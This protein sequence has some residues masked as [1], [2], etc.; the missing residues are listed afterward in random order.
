VVPASREGRR[1]RGDVDGLRA[2]AIL[3]VVAFHVGVPGFSG[4]FVGVDVFFVISGFLITGNLLTES[5][6][7][8]R[9]GLVRFWARRIRRLVPPLALMLVVVSVLTLAILPYVEWQTVAAQ[10]RAAALYVSNLV[11]ARQ[12]TDYFAP[13]VNTSLFLHTWSLGVEEQF[14]L[15]WPVLVVAAAL[16][17]RRRRRWLRPLLAVIFSATLV[18]SFA[19]CL[20]QTTAGSPYAFF[21]LPARAWEF[22]AAGLLALSPVPR[23]LARRVPQLAAFVVGAGL[24]VTATLVYDQQSPYPG[25]R[26]LLPVVG[27]VLMILAGT[28]RGAATT[29]PLSVALSARPMQW[30]GRVSYSW[31]LWHWPFILLAVEAVDADTLAVRG[32]AALVALGVATLAHE[33]IENPVRFNPMLNRSPARTYALGVV[34]T[35]VAIT[36]TVGLDTASARAADHGPKVSL[37]A[38]QASGQSFSCARTVKT[39]DG[40]VYCE[41]GDLQSHQTL[42]LEGDSHTRHWSPAFAQA[43]K[44]VGVKLFVRWESVCP[45]FPI[46]INTLQGVRSTACDRYRAQTAKLIDRLHPTAVVLSQSDFVWDL[47]IV[48]RA[49]N[50]EDARAAIWGDAYDSYLAS[51]RAKGIKLGAVVDTPRMTVNPVDCL[52]KHTAARCSTPRT[53]ALG[54]QRPMAVAEADARARLRSVPTLDINSTLC[55]ATT[56]HAEAN[57]T[58]VYVD[59]DHLYRGFVLTEVP[60]VESFIRQVMR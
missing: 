51:L 9:P 18:A 37:A 47:L 30:L 3:L 27:A 12:A 58:Y 16:A 52:V 38:V 25:A 5:D 60:V 10:G 40:I 32:A 55:D 53:L 44:A 48:P 50:S 35:M 45:A 21:G 54:R 19:L 41:D 59:L 14:Y 26:A 33:L 42:L 29:N 56:C 22:A 57:G 36:A 4:G 34:I 1:F 23:V 6:A 39:A 11:F 20:H 7:A 46:P 24:I 43:A 31:Y 28:G 13:N 49:E 8:G 2:V 15:V 17:V